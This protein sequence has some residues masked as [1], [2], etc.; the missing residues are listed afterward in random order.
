MK[1]SILDDYFDTL[2]TLPCFAKLTGHEIEIWNDHVQDIDVLAARLKDTDCLALIR[3]RTKIQATLLEQLPKLKLVSQRSV[4]PHIDVE[5]CTRLGIVV[6]SSQHVGSP[7]Y[8]AAELTWALILAS[9]RQLPQ[10]MES[11]KAGKWQIGVGTTLRGKTLGIFGYGRIGATVAG[12]G[13]AFGMNVMTWAREESLERARLDGYATARS[14]GEFFESCDVM[15]LHMRLVP[16]TD[17]IVKAEDL[18]RMKPTAILVNTSRAPLIEPGALVAALHQGRPGFAAVD[19]F[20]DEPMRNLD[21]PLMQFKQVVATPHIGY[22]TREEYE[23]QFSD[24]FDQIIA[25]ALGRPINVVNPNVLTA[26]ERRS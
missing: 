3:E 6:S 2:R 17:H 8:A 16:A 20:E 26:A 24:V 13:K 23:T 18:A 12:Y 9:A 21:L 14:K 11:L 1:I 7:S 5:T 4:Y 19:V 15:S 25:F 22:V 10:Q